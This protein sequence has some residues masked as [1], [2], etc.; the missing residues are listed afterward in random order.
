MTRQRRQSPKDRV[1]LASRRGDHVAGGPHWRAKSCV[2]LCGSE[3]SPRTFPT[4]RLALVRSL[5]SVL[6]ERPFELRRVNKAPHRRAKTRSRQIRLQLRPRPNHPDQTRENIAGTGGGRGGRI[7][8]TALQSRP[9]SSSVP[10]TGPAPSRIEAVAARGRVLDAHHSEVQRHHRAAR[11]HNEPHNV[12]Q[13][14]AGA[15]AGG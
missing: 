13:V 15:R 8:G 12:V 6:F 3:P 2:R 10:P 7:S 9:L 11:P 14:V 5:L 1:P 4:L